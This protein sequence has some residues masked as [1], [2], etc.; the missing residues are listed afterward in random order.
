MVSGSVGLVNLIISVLEKIE[1]SQRAL[2]Q[3]IDLWQEK[4]SG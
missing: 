3:N 1:E 4:N 2:A